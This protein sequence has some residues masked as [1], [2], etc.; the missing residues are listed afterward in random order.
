MT[1]DYSQLMKPWY[2]Q[3][4]AQKCSAE[5]KP[6]KAIVLS[7]GAIHPSILTKYCVPAVME[8]QLWDQESSLLT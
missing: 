1:S 4:E 6:R 7:R 5:P 8:L 3:M 2:E